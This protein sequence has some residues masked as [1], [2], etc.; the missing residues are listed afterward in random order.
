MGLNLRVLREHNVQLG[1]SEWYNT[2]MYGERLAD[3][4]QLGLTTETAD[5][6]RILTFANNI[7]GEHDTL[8][9]RLP[10]ARRQRVGNKLAWAAL[11]KPRISFAGKDAQLL[12]D[13]L[14]LVANVDI[15]K[16]PQLSVLAQDAAAAYANLLPDAQ[17]IAIIEDE[18][19]DIMHSNRSIC[20]WGYDFNTG[21]VVFSVTGNTLVQL[22]GRI[23]GI[24]VTVELINTDD[25]HELLSSRQK[26]Q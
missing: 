25:K 19:H 17:R 13:S 8:T 12:A 14:E 16:H 24:P 10:F 22:P 26:A 9:E 3:G 5:D 7:A 21:F 20:D 23:R 18:A 1:A 2:T 6:I 15:N 4:T 11:G